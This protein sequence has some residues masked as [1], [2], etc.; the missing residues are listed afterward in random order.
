MI[1]CS[2]PEPVEQELKTLLAVCRFKEK[3]SIKW[4]EDAGLKLSFPA[5][6]E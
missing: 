1:F 5:T 6:F 2:R 4:N 3:V